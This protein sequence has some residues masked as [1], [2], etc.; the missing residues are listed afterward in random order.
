MLIGVPREIKNHE[1]RVGLTPS[2]VRELVARGHQVIVETNAGA[3][4]G[5]SDADYKMAGAVAVPTADEVFANAEMI[6]KVKEPQAAERARLKPGQVLFTYLHLAP[7][8]EQT[9]D[10]VAS[11]AVCIAYETVTSNSGG[12]PLLAPMSEVAGRMSIQSGAHCL[13]KAS[14]GRGMLLGGVPGVE[15]AKVVILGGGVVGSNAAIMAIGMGAQVIVLDRSLDTLRNLVR[16]FGTR[17]ETVYSTGDAVERHVLSAD[18][19]IGGVLIPGAAAPKLVTRDMIKRMKP[20]AVVVDVA[21][22]QGGCFE[23]SHATTHADP[24]YVV[25]GVVHYCVANM[26][27]GVPRTSTFALNNATLPYVLALAS[28]GYKRALLD[29]PHL[30]NGLNIHRGAV[31]YEAV[32]RA[33]GY[34]YMPAAEALL[35]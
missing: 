4:I 35:P 14:G 22:D 12:L 24:T 32:A 3:G 29:D 25:D 26:P 2:S 10:L 23:T 13:E 1:Y 21:I 11:G 19:V 6:V 27:G 15:P 33:L 17:I 30:A 34:A 16:Q 5:C 20:G 9:E 28:K 8:P 18:L 31:T 7:D